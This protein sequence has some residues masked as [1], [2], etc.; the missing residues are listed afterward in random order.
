V[1]LVVVLLVL[2][3]VVLA[4]IA[5]API[6]LVQRYR[7]GTA[8]RPARGWLVAINVLGIALS[9]GLFL[10]AA[11]VTSTWVP[12]ALAWTSAGLAGGCLLGLV[13]LALTRWEPTPRA[14]YY[15]P[16]RWLVLAITLVVAVRVL[17]GFWRSWHA[18]RA[19]F[20]YA[21]WTVASG[22]AG[23]MAAGAVVLGY[24]LVYWIGVRRRLT[25]G[26]RIRV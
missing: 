22:L 20:E 10:A 8:R 13:G 2:P 18:W 23:S 11:A 16:N 9:A 24:Y 26:S 19:G 12:H 25:A 17:Y 1:P 14:L 5:L 21:S 3:L 4:A 6:A 15:T 7:L